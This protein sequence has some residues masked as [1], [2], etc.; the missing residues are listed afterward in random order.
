MRALVG[1]LRAADL[2]NVTART[3]MIERVSPRGCRHGALSGSTRFSEAPGASVCGP[4]CR[5]RTM[6]NLLALV[7]SASIS[8]F[9]LRR[10]DFHFL[11]SF[12]L[13]TGEI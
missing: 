11:Q 7:R 9:A 13:V 6:L 1:V 5:K 3:V 2:Q 4:I 10:P 8:Q 12:T